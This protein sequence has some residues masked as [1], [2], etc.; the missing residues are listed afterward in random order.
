MDGRIDQRGG[1]TSLS[2]GNVLN[3][4]STIVKGISGRTLSNLGTINW[5]GT[6]SINGGNAVINNQPGGVFDAQGDA[7]IFTNTTV[8]FNNSGLFKKSAGTGTTSVDGFNNTGTVKVRSG[9]LTLNFGNG[10]NTGVFDVSAGA[11]LNFTNFS[12]TLNTIYSGATFSGAGA[13]NVNNYS[14]LSDTTFLNTGPV[15]LN[16]TMNVNGD[17]NL[18]KVFNWN[19]GSMSGLGTTTIPAGNTL[20]VSPS[21]SS[22]VRLAGRTLE[23]AGTIT[24]SADRGAVDLEHR[25]HQ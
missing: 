4:S 13:L 25:H 5:A 12:G 10:T 17:L 9:T 2:K 19:S 23:N 3:W 16:A 1:T 11:T 20:N 18:P 15:T 7:R 24:F 8:A 22:D 6:G 14:T 21:T